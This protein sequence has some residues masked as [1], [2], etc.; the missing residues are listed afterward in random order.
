M[1]LGLV[2]SP[3]AQQ[4]PVGLGRLRA[5]SGF[6][7]TATVWDWITGPSLMSGCAANDPNC[8]NGDV[9]VTDVNAQM[10]ST[11][12]YYQITPNCWGYSQAAWLQAYQVVSGASTLPAPVPVAAPTQA[13]LDA[14][15]ASP[16]PG[17]AATALTQSL[18]NASVAATQTQDTAWA[19]TVPSAP[20]PA[21]VSLIPGLNVSTSLL[22][23]LAGGGLLL[24]YVGT[25]K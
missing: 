25:H 14:V 21:A 2:P 5:A 6:G 10:C 24:F 7:D 17:T 13:Q 19:A 9:G 23:L 4:I 11:D 1:M 3:A 22:L 12:G 16:D 18:S 15:A 8:I 20:V